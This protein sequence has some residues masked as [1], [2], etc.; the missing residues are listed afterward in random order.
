MEAQKKLTVCLY[1]WPYAQ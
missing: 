1:D